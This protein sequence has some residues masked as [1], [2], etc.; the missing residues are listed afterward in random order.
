MLDDTGQWIDLTCIGRDGRPIHGDMSDL[1]RPIRAP[2]TRFILVIEKEGIYQELSEA[3]FFNQM[4]CILVTA[5]GVPDV[6]TR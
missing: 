5:H 3:R 2:K 4:P 6:A 1:C